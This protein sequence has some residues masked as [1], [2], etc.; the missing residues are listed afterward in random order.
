[1]TQQERR[2]L[3]LENVQGIVTQFAADPI[4]MEA[5]A[6]HEPTISEI[7]RVFEEKLREL[8]PM[9]PDWDPRPAGEADPT[10]KATL[11][12]DEE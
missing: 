9:R 8:I 10:L 12:G 3:I 5:I 2:K 1:M 11:P 4:V 7:T 6:A